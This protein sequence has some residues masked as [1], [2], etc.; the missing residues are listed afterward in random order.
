[1]NYSDFY[2]THIEYKGSI[3]LLSRK[4]KN[5]Y[6]LFS[7][8][9]TFKAKKHDLSEKNAVFRPFRTPVPYGQSSHQ[10]QKILNFI[11]D[12]IIL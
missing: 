1:M 9:R 2:L 6:C 10:V 4:M 7:R 8:F 3:D 11:L 12:L 5:N